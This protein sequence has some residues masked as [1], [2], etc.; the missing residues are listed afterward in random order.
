MDTAKKQKS[1]PLANS[2][3][4]TVRSVEFA[5]VISPTSSPDSIVRVDVAKSIQVLEKALKEGVFSSLKNDES[6]N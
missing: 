1:N 3:T 6:E 5:G 4:S 2:A